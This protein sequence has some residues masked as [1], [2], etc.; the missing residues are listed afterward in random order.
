MLDLLQIFKMADFNYNDIG[1]KDYKEVW[2]QQEQTL[3]EIIAEKRETKKPTSK[4]EFIL[5]E[6]PH[7]YTLGKSGDEKNL[8]PQTV[9]LKK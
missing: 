9:F 2:D 6:H 4:N 3:A 1:L 8:L 5:V 7:V